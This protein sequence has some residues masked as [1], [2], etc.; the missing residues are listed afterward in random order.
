MTKTPETLRSG[1]WFASSGLRSF[2]HRSRLRQLGVDAE[3]QAGKPIIAIINTWSE[4][5]PCQ[6]HL[7][8]RAEQVKRGVWQ[9]GGFPVEFGASTL[10]ETY[11]KPTPM[12]YRNLLAMEAEETL[13]SFTSRELNDLVSF[14]MRAASASPASQSTAIAAQSGSSS[15]MKTAVPCHAAGLAKICLAAALVLLAGSR[16]SISSAD[17]AKRSFSLEAKSPKFW[18]LVS[19]DAKLTTVATGF[20]F[21]EGPVWDAGGFLYVSDETLNKMRQS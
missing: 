8:E 2:S 14:L 9:A 7:R 1:G 21:T 4:L 20:G 16:M 11:C 5:N 12:M 19:K 18:K 3:G 6:M 17:E 15:P 10:S 13:R